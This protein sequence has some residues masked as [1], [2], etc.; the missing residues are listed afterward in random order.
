MIFLVNYP[1]PQGFRPVH[2]CSPPVPAD[3]FPRPRTVGMLRWCFLEPYSFSVSR[4][5]ANTR[6]LEAALFSDSAASQ[7]KDAA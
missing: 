1:C 3:E 2:P 4:Y 6:S 7:I 5:T